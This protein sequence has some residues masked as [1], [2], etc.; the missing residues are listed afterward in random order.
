MG[1]AVWAVVPEILDPESPCNQIR[2]HCLGWRFL[3]THFWLGLF[4]CA[5]LCSVFHR[6]I[7]EIFSGSVIAAILE[8]VWHIL[9]KMLSVSV[10]EST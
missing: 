2:I 3:A 10:G 5:E 1:V 6:S 9:P 7:T 4:F 8:L